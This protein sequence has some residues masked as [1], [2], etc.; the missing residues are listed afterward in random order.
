MLLSV[1]AT[2]SASQQPTLPEISNPADTGW[3]DLTFRIQHVGRLPDGTQLVRAAGS[4]R[5]VPVAFAVLLGSAWKAG[6]L[7]PNLPTYTGTVTVR[8]LGAPSNQLLRALDEIYG[9][10]R[11]AQ[12]M[13][14]RTE[15]SVITLEGDPRRLS[16]GP[17]KLKL[18]FESDDG[19]QYAELYLNI[20]RGQSTLELAEKDPD[21]RAAIVRALSAR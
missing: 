21:Y 10:R 11:H 16:A 17:V 6:S 19:T 12:T 13:R 9:T 14:P 1:G 5:G 18:F 2:V 3:H 7:G 4:H 8:S 15:F 20:D